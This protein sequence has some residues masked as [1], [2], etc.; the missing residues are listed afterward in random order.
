MVL[1]ESA[2]AGWWDIDFASYA[3]AMAL[4]E[5]AKARAL[6]AVPSG[7]P[8]ARQLAVALLDDARSSWHP[9]TGAR[10]PANG[11]FPSLLHTLMSCECAGG[12]GAFFSQSPSF[13]HGVSTSCVQSP[14]FPTPHFPRH[15]YGGAA[16][17]VPLKRVFFM[18]FSQVW[19][20]PA[21][22]PARTSFGAAQRR[23]PSLHHLCLLFHEG[24]V[25]LYIVRVT[26]SPASGG[27]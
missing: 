6:R 21:S 5:D 3:L 24:T 15:L 27:P 16:G 23:A 22:L 18:G 4:G 25:D 17:P 7:V 1:P 26:S 13:C 11:T 20:H 14:L 2:G 9:H 10:S 8:A 12:G 19:L